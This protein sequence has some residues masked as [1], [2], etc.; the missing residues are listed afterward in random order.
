MII[1][2]LMC[3]FLNISNALEKCKMTYFR[4]SCGY[5]DCT[6][7]LW[8]GISSKYCKKHKLIRLGINYTCKHMTCKLLR[9]TTS[10]IYLSWK[11]VEK[12]I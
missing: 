6:R 8:T 2:F 7:S 11:D 9:K 3:Y 4:R 5:K 10:C 12:I 1:K